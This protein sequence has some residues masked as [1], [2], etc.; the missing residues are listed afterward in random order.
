MGTARALETCG[1][2]AMAQHAPESALR[3]VGAAMAL[4]RS[5]SAPLPEAERAGLD[6][7]LVQWRVRVGTRKFE[8][9]LAEGESMAPEDAIVLARGV[10]ASA[11]AGNEMDVL[12]ARERE[13]A[14]LVAR[15]M[16]NPQIARELVIG[17]RTAQSHV[18]SILAKLG[19]SSRVQIAAWVIEHPSARDP[20]RSAS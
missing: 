5:I 18:A 13:V 19:L 3:L 11:L 10:A 7:R 17:D 9:A 4:R 2:L 8:N 20:R 12:S 14:A 16:T 6:K 15:G 1:Y